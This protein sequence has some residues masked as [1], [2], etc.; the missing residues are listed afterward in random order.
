MLTD[1]LLVADT[2]FLS[3]LM[4]GVAAFA[5]WRRIWIIEYSSTSILFKRE[6]LINAVR[7]CGNVAPFF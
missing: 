1:D 3:S 7:S 5:G 6:W 2:H 4:V